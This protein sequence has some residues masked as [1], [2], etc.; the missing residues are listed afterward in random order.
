MQ[1]KQQ[2][3]NLLWACVAAR[4][5]LFDSDKKAST[6]LGLQI[7]LQPVLGAG[8]IFSAYHSINLSVRF[9]IWSNRFV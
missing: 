8:S 7:N 6:G 5:D 1:P 3:K 4:D 9:Q 2:R